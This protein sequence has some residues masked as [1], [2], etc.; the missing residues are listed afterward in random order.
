MVSLRYVLNFNS[1]TMTYTVEMEDSNPG[2]G[3]LEQS[4][5]FSPHMAI[6]SAVFVRT[7]VHGIQSCLAGLFSGKPSASF[8]YLQLGGTGK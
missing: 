8:T 4:N 2:N 3:M 6:A 5:C 1:Q 7:L